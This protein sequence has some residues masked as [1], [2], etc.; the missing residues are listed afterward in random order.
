M[1]IALFGGSFDPP[2][3]GH[4]KIVHSILAN[5]DIDKLIIMPTF[6]NPFKEKFSA[7]PNLRLSWA[8]KLW[9]NL[10]KTEICEFEILQ[11]E[12]VPS[13]KSVEFLRQKYEQ[14]EI[15][16]IIGADNLSSLHKW[17][18]FDE[19]KNL[20]KFVVFARNDIEIPSQIH[21][22]NLQKMDLNVNISSSFFRENL[23]GEIPNLIKNDVINFYKEIKMGENSVEQRAEKIAGI[24]NDKKAENVEIIDMSEKDY[25]AKFVVIATTLTGR[26]GAA[27]IDE[28]KSVL[29]PL[30]EEFLAVESS[31]EWSVVDL[32]DIIIHL[33]DERYRAKYNI[34]EFL[35]KLKRNEFA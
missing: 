25:I 24:L 34:E 31:D 26:H 18:K 4:D 33:M 19:L 21:G 8:K 32:G 28:L 27:L 14:S 17:H 13:I 11:N 29:K 7:P 10:P 5:F 30:G 20:V 16:L 9:G 23:I 6:L 2:H 22:V 3:A 15:F 1:K 35:E 12:K